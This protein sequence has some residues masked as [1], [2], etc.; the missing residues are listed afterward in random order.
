MRTSREGRQPAWR[1][2]AMVAALLFAAALQGREARAARPE[3][4]VTVRGVVTDA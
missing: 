4:I 2:V 1:S 3:T